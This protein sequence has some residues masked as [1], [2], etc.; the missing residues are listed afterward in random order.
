MKGTINL[1]QASCIMGILVFANKVLILPSVM[2]EKVGVDGIFLLVG[3]FLVDL[4]MLWVFFKLK[5]KFP[6]KTFFELLTK[7]IT[8][9]GAI[10]VYVL[11][12]GFFVMKALT[13]YNVSLMYLKNQVYFEAG[14]FLFLICFLTLSN[15]LALRGLRSTART[16]EFFY[17]GII[18]LIVLSTYAAC[19]NFGELPVFFNN[20][21]GKL[22]TS[23]FNYLFCFGDVLFLF[24]IMDKIEI[25]KEK[26]RTMYICV[27]VNMVLTFL[28]YGVFFSVFKYT[29]FMHNN[30]ASDV[31]TFS[32]NFAG[33]GRIDI[34][35]VI[36]IMFLNYFQLSFFNLA[37]QS[38]FSAIFPK[39]NKI[40][41]TIIYDLLFVVLLY[42]FVSDYTQVFAI[43]T[44][45][46]PYFALVLQYIIPTICLVATL[47]KRR[48]EDE[49]IS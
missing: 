6:D 11:F 7:V 45:I 17:F 39:G 16:T 42:F 4:F 46:M 25:K 38:S 27:I 20:S 23:S 44:N 13:I 22:F 36:V 19:A 24:L 28:L 8:K 9:Y 30:A 12:C 35:S 26:Q 49:E 47:F 10:F 3:L 31:I 5:H 18:L 14:E 43:D 48:K 32:N 37:F 15:N 2:F 33:V 1:R 41:S 40:I 34:L 29:G 21:L